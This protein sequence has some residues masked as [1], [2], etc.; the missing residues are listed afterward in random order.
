MAI[1][2]TEISYTVRRTS[3]SQR[4]SVCVRDDGSINITAPKRISDQ[5]IRR[6][7]DQ[8][9][10]WIIDAIQRTKKRPPG[11]LLTATPR[12]RS[13]LIVTTRQFVGERLHHWNNFY[14]HRLGTIKI[15]DQKSRWG[16]CSKNGD[17]SFNYRL[18]LLPTDLADYVVVHEL[19]HIGQF[20]HS[21]KFWAL[22]AQTIPDWHDRRRRLNRDWKIA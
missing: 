10:Q 9:A 1:T 4:L 18:A 17:L 21:K 3:R 14:H 13:K 20:N 8:Q 19:C 16:S 12:E 22:V 2:P 11:T 15:R 6:F 7:V 5:F